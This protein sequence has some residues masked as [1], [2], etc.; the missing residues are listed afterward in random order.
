M[1]RLVLL[2]G[3]AAC[4]KKE[5]AKPAPTPAPE[6]VAKAADAAVAVEAPTKLELL[7]AGA[8]PKQVLHYQLTKGSKTSLELTTDIDFTAGK[9]GGPMPSL[10]MTMDIGADDVLPDGKMK[11][12]SVI[13]RVTAKDRAGAK[14]SADTISAQ[15]AIMVG[16][17]VVGTLGTDG[18]LTDGHID[19]GSQN[20]P[21][22]M[23]AQLGTL[24]KGF[25]RVALSLPTQPVGVGA[26]WRTS[27][28][29]IENGAH[30]TAVTTIELTKVEGTVISFKRTSVIT[31]PDQKLQQMGV[32]LEMKNIHGK[33]E[34][35]GT[36]D[37][38]KMA[39]VGA[40]TDELHDEVS[41]GGQQMIA[42]MKMVSTYRQ[43]AQTAP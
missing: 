23:Q 43:G 11:V 8:E 36:L 42:D 24:T 22:E 10:V 21:P 26:K 34:G 27:K 12:K 20:L 6:P 31:A 16:I 29:V 33:G 15:A 32:D 28:E 3:L 14:M 25:E 41:G 17:G 9:M 38:S 5:E 7:E 18:T 19:Y 13:S 40:M 37:L 4:G 30:M 1:K 39:L 35:E 2:I